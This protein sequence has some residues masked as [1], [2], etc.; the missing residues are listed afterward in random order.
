MYKCEIF[1]EGDSGYI[2]I[3]CRY[4]DV[5][6][7]ELAFESADKFVKVY[8]IP[9]K[10]TRGDSLDDIVCYWNAMVGQPYMACL[11]LEVGGESVRYAESRE[12]LLFAPEVK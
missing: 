2:P 6:S 5:D 12:R 8:G 7:D 1:K 11:H 4:F 10:W 3:G 9:E